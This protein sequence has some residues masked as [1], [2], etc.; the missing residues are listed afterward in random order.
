MSRFEQ[1]AEAARETLA[2]HSV[3]NVNSTAAGGGVAELLQT[4]LA[5]VRGIGID[6]RWLVIEG[7]PEF[8]AITKRDPQR[9]LRLAG[10]RRPARRRPSTAHYEH[11]LAGATPTSCSRVVRADDVVLLHDPQ[12]AG[13]AAAAQDAGRARRVALPRRPRSP[14]RVDA[15]GRGSSC[16]PTWPKVDAIVV[17]RAA[18]APP[19]VDP[20][21]GARD[22]ALDRSLLGE[23]RADLSARRHC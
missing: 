7:D 22:P 18:F 4:L 13:L 2:G 10:R 5:Y 11:V 21:A 19:W 23:E 9:P 20:A 6:A 8:F 17:S 1:A 3:L 16:A 14:E 12:T 15:S